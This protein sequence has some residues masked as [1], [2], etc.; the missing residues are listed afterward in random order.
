MFQTING[1]QTMMNDKME[2]VLQEIKI[3]KEEN[4]L[5]KKQVIEKRLDYPER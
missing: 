4:V 1:N 5:L 3:I 2:G